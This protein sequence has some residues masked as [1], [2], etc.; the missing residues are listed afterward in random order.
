MMSVTT[1]SMLHNYHITIGRS[2]PI[3]RLIVALWLAS[4]SFVEAAES[5]TLTWDADA[6]PDIAGYRLYSG[7]SSGTYTESIDVGNITVATIPNLTA[8]ITYFCVVTAYNTAGLESGPSNEASFTLPVL[9]QPQPPQQ[10]RPVLSES[11]RL[12]DG[13]FQF[14]LSS[15]TGV[16]NG[17]SI[18]FSNDLKTWTLLTSAASK[19]SGNG[20]VVV[21]DQ[22]AALVNRRFYR[23]ST[24]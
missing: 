10:S 23:V 21:T 8:G 17:V 15:P 19:A 11:R 6:S 7:T 22:G 4:L 14:T 5:I 20:T 18:F 16:V 24:D 1:E 3:A 2:I 9:D 13:S 12:P